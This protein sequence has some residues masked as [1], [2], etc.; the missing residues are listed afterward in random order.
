MSRKKSPKPFRNRSR[1]KSRIN[2]LRP[3]AG[4]LAAGLRFPAVPAAQSVPFPTYLTG[5]PP[6]DCSKV[7]VP[8]DNSFITC[9]PN[10]PIGDYGRTCGTFYNTGTSY[11]GGIAVTQDGKS[12]Y[13]LL[14]QNDTI[15]KI[16]LTA[17]QLRQGKQIRV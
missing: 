14:N 10:S 2:R 16:D 17:A 9:F 3:L 4:L 1:N 5:P 13:A 12:A 11:P 8:P 15:T 7:R 6:S